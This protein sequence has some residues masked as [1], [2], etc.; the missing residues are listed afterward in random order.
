MANRIQVKS[1]KKQRFSSK[2]GQRRRGK[3]RMSVAE[4]RK[5]RLLT[6]NQNAV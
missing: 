5:F 1:V 2:A 4:K 6:Q 3:N